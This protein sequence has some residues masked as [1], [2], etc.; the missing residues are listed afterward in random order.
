MDVPS[1][2]AYLE[3]K[4]DDLRKQ[5][6]VIDSMISKIW[7]DNQRERRALVEEQRI[8]SEEANRLYREI[9]EGGMEMNPAMVLKLHGDA[10]R[11]DLRVA[12]AAEKHAEILK[13]NRCTGEELREELGYYDMRDKLEANNLE[14]RRLKDE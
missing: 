12:K 14:I 4:N 6:R 1:I 9:R 11:A 8:Y 13:T 10:T 5:M 7:S 2:I 3:E